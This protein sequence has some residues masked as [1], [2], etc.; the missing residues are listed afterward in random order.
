MA[1]VSDQELAKLKAE[2][3]LLQLVEGR[4]IRLV[5]H[6]KDY[7]G[8]CPFHDDRDPSLVIS[9]DKNLWHCLGVCQTG[10]TVIDWVMR[11]DGLS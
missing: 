5:K 1:R 6:G 2:V 4:G 8:L 3:N 11:T 9:P 10:G 7:L